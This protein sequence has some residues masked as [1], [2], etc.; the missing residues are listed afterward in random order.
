MPVRI[1]LTADRLAP[2][3][4]LPALRDVELRHADEPLMERAGAAAADIAAAMLARQRGPVA[5]LAGPGNNGGDACVCARHL[6]ARGFDVAIAWAADPSRL[7]PAAAAAYAEASAA[8]VRFVPAP[9]SRRPALVVDGLFGI[10]LSRPVTPPYDGWIE[11][12]NAQ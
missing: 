7:A 11:W 1:D 2:V 9:P 10:G 12:A 8:G 4:P 5:I 3:L 6:H